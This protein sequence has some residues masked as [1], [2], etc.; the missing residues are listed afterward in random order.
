MNNIIQFPV[1]ID[2]EDRIGYVTNGSKIEG[3]YVDNLAAMI[4]NGNVYIGTKGYDEIN[5]ATLTNMKD[6]NEFCL[7]WLLIFNS[8]VI[9]EDL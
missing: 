6:L 2:N 5:N 8:G 7:M 1:N 4:D 9:K 3:V